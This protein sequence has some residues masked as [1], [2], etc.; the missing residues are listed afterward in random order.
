M[1]RGRKVDSTR[2]LALSNIIQLDHIMQFIS[3]VPENK[4][5]QGRCIGAHVMVSLT[6][7]ISET[8]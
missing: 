4:I 6:P 3:L 8:Q 7:A 2:G 1:E 5:A